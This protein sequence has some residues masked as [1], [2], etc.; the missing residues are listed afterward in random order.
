MTTR[1]VNNDIAPCPPDRRALLCIDLQRLGI[2]PG[3]GAFSSLRRVGI[4]DEDIEAFRQRMRDTV[5]PNVAQLQKHFRQAGDE[6]IHVRIQSLTRDGRDRSPE[7]KRLGLLAAPG[8]A[9]AEFLPEV[10]PEGDEIIINKTASGVFIATNLEFVLR[11]LGVSRLVIVGVYTNECVSSAVRSASD[12][13]FDTTVVE[14][15]T[16]AISPGMHTAALDI[17]RDRYAQVTGTKDLL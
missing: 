1:R 12:L 10:A 17:I 15:A 7:H 3:H 11:S 4:S 6:V 16:A 14:D 13:G 5:L 2:E 8:S 9:E